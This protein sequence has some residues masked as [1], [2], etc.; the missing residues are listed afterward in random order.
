MTTR[1][2]PSQRKLYNERALLLA[3]HLVDGRKYWAHF[4]CRPV[5]TFVRGG[6]RFYHVRVC[7]STFGKPEGP[8][9]CYAQDT[10]QD[11]RRRFGKDGKE[12]KRE[13]KYI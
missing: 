4:Y 11:T 5:K 13:P 10:L 6:T 1:I 9:Y 7:D 2:L 12:Y 3:L 8:I